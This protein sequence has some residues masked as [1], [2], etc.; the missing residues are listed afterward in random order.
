M[1]MYNVIKDNMKKKSIKKLAK[2]A[3]RMKGMDRK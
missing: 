1:S 2:N 3:M